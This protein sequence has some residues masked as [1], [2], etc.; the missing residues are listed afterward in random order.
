LAFRHAHLDACQRRTVDRL[1]QIAFIGARH[2][3]AALWILSGLIGGHVEHGTLTTCAS[4][5][6][7][8]Q[9]GR[10]WRWPMAAFNSSAS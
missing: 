7:L 6:M 4:A 9:C 1:I 10:A 8:C 5:A 3:S 2:C